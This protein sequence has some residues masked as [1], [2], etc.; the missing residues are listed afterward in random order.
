MKTW[1]LV[2]VQVLCLSVYFFFPAVGPC[3][4]SVIHWRSFLEH[5]ENTECAVSNSDTFVFCSSNKKFEMV[6]I[7]AVK[8]SIG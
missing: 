6:L 4:C 3:S 7:F 2:L 8:I 1:T 5:D